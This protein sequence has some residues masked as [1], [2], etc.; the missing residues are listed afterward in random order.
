MVA[1]NIFDEVRNKKENT[2]MGSAVFEVGHL[3]GARGNTLKTKLQKGGVVIA[4]V[5]KLQ[6]LSILEIQLRCEHLTNTKG[7]F[8]AR[9]LSSV[10]RL[11]LQKV[12]HGECIDFLKALIF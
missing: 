7:V 2:A 4:T 9:S 3:L 10:E 1:I 12:R 5:R 8:G 6:G 11:V